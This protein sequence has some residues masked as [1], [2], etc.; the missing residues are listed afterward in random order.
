MK[1]APETSSP[2]RPRRPR[3]LLPVARPSFP[4][5]LFPLVAQSLPAHL[6]APFSPASLAGCRPHSA[7]RS[8]AHRRGAPKRR[9]PADPPASLPTLG[10]QR[11][12]SGPPASETERPRVSAPARRPRPRPLSPTGRA[13]LSSPTS[14]LPRA[15]TGRKRDHCRDLR[16]SLTIP[17]AENLGSPL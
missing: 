5:S 11:S 14:R 17:H 8:P 15:R 16:H 1:R 2:N 7:Q 6:P 13:R 12:T 4:F 3:S 9:T 10:P